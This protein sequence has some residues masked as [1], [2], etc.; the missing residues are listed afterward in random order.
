MRFKIGDKIINNTKHD[1]VSSH[2]YDHV[3]N[4]KQFTSEK[5]LSLETI[6][7]LQTVIDIDDDSIITDFIL[8]D[9]NNYWFEIGSPYSRS[10]KKVK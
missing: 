9:G 6:G 5:D 7:K 2:D 8:S 3:K 4:Y 1:E 10:C